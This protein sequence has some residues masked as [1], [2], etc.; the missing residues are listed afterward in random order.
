MI[1]LAIM[2][3]ID[4]YLDKDAARIIIE[5]PNWTPALFQGSPVDIYAKVNISYRL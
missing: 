4:H 2:E 1:P 3:G 5:S